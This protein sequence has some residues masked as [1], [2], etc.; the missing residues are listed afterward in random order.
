VSNRLGN[1]EPFFPEGTALSEC[2]QLGVAPGKSHLAWHSR[3]EDLTE[4]LTAA[5]PVEERHSLPEAVD[6]PT[7]VSLGMGSLAERQIRQRVLGDVPASRGECEG[8][9]GGSDGLVIYAHGVEVA[10]QND[11]DLSQPPRIVKGH[12][13]GLGLA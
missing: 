8:T 1:P 2:P 10:R 4:A 7:I 3:Q 13:E 9:L 11:R 6:R 12:R 5:R